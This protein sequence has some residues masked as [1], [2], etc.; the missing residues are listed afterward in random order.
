MCFKLEGRRLVVVLLLLFGGRR[1]DDKDLLLLLVCVCVCG[2][3]GGHG[4]VDH[5]AV[6]VA[7]IVIGVGA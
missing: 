4:Q 1:E 6:G 3:E 2:E 7:G 5:G